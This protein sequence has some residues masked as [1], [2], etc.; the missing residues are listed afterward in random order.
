M[1]PLGF[2]MQGPVGGPI[3]GMQS[4]QA[5]VQVTIPEG[6]MPGQTMATQT[7]DGQTVQFQCP[8]GAGPGTTMMVAYTPWR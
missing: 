4:G 1:Q 2:G 8:P 6:M 7:P 3:M 5:H